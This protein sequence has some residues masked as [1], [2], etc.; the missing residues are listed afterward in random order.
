MN[1]QHKDFF[2]LYYTN[3]YLLLCPGDLSGTFRARTRT[4]AYDWL[5]CKMRA[6]PRCSLNSSAGN[7]FPFLHLY[8]FVP[9]NLRKHKSHWMRLQQC[10]C[11]LTFHWITDVSVILRSLREQCGKKRK[12]SS[13]EESDVTAMLIG[14]SD[15][16]LWTACFEHK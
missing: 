9:P 10:C 11:Y 4:L 16:R 6:L 5:S 12:R 3:I 14:Y 1:Y 8:I 2:V 7:F 15:C 13:L